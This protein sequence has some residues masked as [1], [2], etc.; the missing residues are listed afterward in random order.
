MRL[1]AF[2]ISTPLA[3]GLVSAAP[4]RAEP[5]AVPKILISSDS[6]T[7]NYAA[8]KVLQGW[9]YY[10]NTYTTLEVRNLARNGH[11]TR[12][13][14]KEGLWSALLDSTA[15]GDYVIIEMGHCDFGN[16]TIAGTKAA[17]RATLPGIGEETVVATLPSGATETVHTFGWYLR[18]M[19]TDVQ[20]KGATSIISGMIGRNFWEGKKLRDNWPFSD[21]AEQVATMAGVEFIDHTE[22]FFALFQS[23]G[24]K[25]A[26]TYFP[27]DNT[28]TNS[29]GAKLTAQAFVQALK[30]KC[31]GASQ[32]AQYLNSAAQ[33]L[34]TPACQPCQ[35]L[36]TEA[37]P[38]S[39]G[40]GY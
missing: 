37:T 34:K 9:G 6:T 20:A 3:S 10:L 30:C 24:P 29:H 36:W 18:Q 12:T 2:F 7:A 11:S 38:D 26:T 5:R 13:F 33:V 31:G 40:P 14:I 1:S 23:F 4:S 15:S 25:K 22:Y 8:D 16:P 39:L 21:Y 17:D 27:I 19:I 32:L 35:Q 28:H